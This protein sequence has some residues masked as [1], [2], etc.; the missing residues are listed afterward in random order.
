[1]ALGN[2]CPDR[3]PPRPS[4]G[5]QPQ[6]LRPGRGS[7]RLAP[8]AVPAG[9]PAGT[10]AAAAGWRSQ[11]LFVRG[12]ALRHHGRHGKPGARHRSAPAPAAREREAAERYAQ[13]SP[14]PPRRP[15]RSRCGCQPRAS[16]QPL[17][18][19]CRWREATRRR[20]AG[21]EPVK[22]ASARLVHHDEEVA[23]HPVHERLHDSEH[24]IGANPGPRRGAAPA[25]SICAA[26]WPPWGAG[27]GDD[28]ARGRDN[29]STRDNQTCA[30]N[31]SVLGPGTG[32][33]LIEGVVWHRRKAGDPGHAGARLRGRLHAGGAGRAERAG[34]L[35]RRSQGGDGGAH[36]AAGGARARAAAHRLPR[37][38][39]DDRPHRR[40]RVQ[41]ARDG[42]F[43]GS[44]IPADL[45]RQWIQGTGPAARPGAPVETS[46]RNVAYALLSGADGWMFD[47]EDAL[48]QVSTHVARQPAQP[49]AG[50]R[51]RP[52]VPAGRRAGRRRDER[53]GARASSAGPSSPTGGSS[54]T[55]PP[56]SS[57]PRGLHLDDRHVRH[58][59]GAGF[60]ASIVDLALYVVN[61]HARPARGRRVVV[62]YLPKIQT[63]EEA[64]LWN[65]MLDRARSSTSACRSARSRSTC[66]SSSSRPASS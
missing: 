64:A 38:R 28:A 47:G 4:L 54:S 45:Q 46:L 12:P 15:A 27:G 17:P 48:G 23:A 57:A 44:E 41:D 16:P 65:D 21:V 14:I 6:R 33:G 7:G 11:R 51:P 1:M 42:N 58:A 53:L 30:R 39:R 32:A 66:S 3:R 10:T 60:S 13:G 35:R 5:D 22:R 63:A 52:G 49:Q 31:T 29:Q 26:A 59:G 55:S 56:R 8:A 61:N 24:G 43:D 25:A 20:S 36:R 19:Q 9:R 62:L 18:A 40:S 2:R 37:S 50:D 34:A